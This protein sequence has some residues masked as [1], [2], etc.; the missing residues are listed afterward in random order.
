MTARP[1]FPECRRRSARIVAALCIVMMALLLVAGCVHEPAYDSQS[2]TIPSP[3]VPAPTQKSSSL[4][5]VTIAQPNDSHAEFIRMDTDVYNQGEIVEFYML[6]SGSKQL[7][8]GSVNPTYFVSYKTD[9]G[10]WNE[11]ASEP[12]PIQ[13]SPSFLDPGHSTPVSRLITNTWKPGLYRISFNC[14]YPVEVTNEEGKSTVEYQSVLHD[15]TLREKPG[16]LTDN[17]EVK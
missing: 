11:I 13:P 4:Y 2:G 1:I 14:Y 17:G 8:C 12:A 10:S 5:K 15:F 16:I 3:A 6:N 7:R 9:N